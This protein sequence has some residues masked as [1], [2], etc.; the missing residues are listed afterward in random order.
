VDAEELRTLLSDAGLQRM[1]VTPRSLDI[2]FPSPEYFVPLTVQAAT[3]I[4]A[5]APLDTAA[6]SALVERVTDETEAVAQRYRNGGK[7]TFP[8]PTHIAVAYA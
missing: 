7:L 6:R 1:E 3:A 4:P 5:F 2:H 8:M